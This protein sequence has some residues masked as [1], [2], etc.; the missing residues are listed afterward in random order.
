MRW[1]LVCLYVIPAVMLFVSTAVPLELSA[2]LLSLLLSE[3]HRRLASFAAFE[4]DLQLHSSGHCLYH[5]QSYHVAR[6]AILSRYLIVLD[7]RTSDHRLRLPIT[8]D[9]VP[10]DVFRHISRVSVSLKS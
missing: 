2:L 7:L 10:H 1:G 6:I 3:T 8:C 4:G 9:A 5:G